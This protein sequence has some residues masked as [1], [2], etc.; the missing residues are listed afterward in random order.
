[1]VD[2]KKIRELLNKLLW[3]YNSIDYGTEE[4]KITLIKDRNALL[5]ELKLFLNF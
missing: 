1:M 4:E 3:V 2:H 5:Q